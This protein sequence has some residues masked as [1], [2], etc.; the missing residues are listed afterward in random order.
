MMSEWEKNGHRLIDVVAIRANSLASSFP[1][2]P[3][4]PGTH[5]KLILQLWKCMRFCRIF[6]M[7]KVLGE[8]L[9]LYNDV[10]IFCIAVLES[11]MIN[12]LEKGGLSF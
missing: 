9:R 4:C 3:T 10:V 12:M 7:N 6:R 11:E 8:H 1:G 2:I 5:M